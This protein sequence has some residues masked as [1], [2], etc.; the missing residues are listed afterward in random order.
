MTSWPQLYRHCQLAVK[1]TRMTQPWLI[2]ARKIRLVCSNASKIAGDHL[3]QYFQQWN[4]PLSAEA[5]A[6][7]NA[8]NLPQP[9]KG[10]AK[11]P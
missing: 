2:A 6:A 8:L 1:L 5:I 4:I 11:T 9:K 3:N 10:I 7:I